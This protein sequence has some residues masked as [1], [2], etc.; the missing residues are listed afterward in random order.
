MEKQN[1]NQK[2]KRAN[3]DTE[4]GKAEIKLKEKERLLTEAERKYIVDSLENRDWRLMVAMCIILL[5]VIVG[6]SW[7]IY[8]PDKMKETIIFFVWWIFTVALGLGD[9]LISANKLLAAAKKREVY[10]KE[11]IFLNLYKYQYGAFEIMQNGKKKYFSCRATLRDEVKVG[12][13]VI[14]VKKRRKYKYVWVYKAR[15]DEKQITSNA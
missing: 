4:C 6:L 11:A 10:I 15:E 5:L 12:E 7:G 13:K 8:S 2:K 3:Y 1:K 9:I 14:L